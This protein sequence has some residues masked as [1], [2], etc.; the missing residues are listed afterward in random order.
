[1]VT[2]VVQ[3]LFFFLFQYGIIFVYGQTISSI[4][5]SITTRS[6]TT[7]GRR[8]TTTKKSS[9]S[10]SGFNVTLMIYILMPIVFMLMIALTIFRIVRMRILRARN[11]I[12]TAATAAFV[13][14]QQSNMYTPPPLPNS[15]M[16][17]VTIIEK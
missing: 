4:N 7:T 17:P 5:T 9:S 16:P 13:V 15:Q 12:H 6:T 11:A 10:G 2:T 1:M 14:Q 8:T 3:K